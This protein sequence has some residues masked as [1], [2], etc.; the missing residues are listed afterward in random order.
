[1]MEILKRN[2]KK[3]PY[4]DLRDYEVDKIVIVCKRTIKEWLQQKQTPFSTVYNK[5]IRELL[6]EL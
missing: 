2:I 4:L 3:I 1:M 5:W 6:E